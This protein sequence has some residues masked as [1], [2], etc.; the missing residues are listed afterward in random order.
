MNLLVSASFIA[1]FFAGVAALFAPCCITVLLPTY[2][3]SIF[4]QKTKVFLMTF[5]YFLG[6]LVVFIPLGLGVTALSTLFSSYHNIIYSIGAIFL[7]FLGLSLLLGRQFSIPFSVHPQLKRY[8]FPSVFILG[9]FSAFATVCCAPV[10][11][12]VLALSI[13]PGS[14]FLGVAYV[15]AYVLGMVL[16]LF[17]IAAFLDKINFTQKF[18]VFRKVVSYKLLGQKIF[19]PFSNLFA[20]LMFFILGIIILFL[21]QENSLTTHAAY[22]A[23]LN[24]FTAKLVDSISVFTR[25]IP[26]PVW[27]LVFVGIFL[28]IVRIAIKEFVDVIKNKGGEN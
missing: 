12:G 27:A 15:L 23:T 7:I 28:L 6:L 14:V 16:P 9:I 2:L 18:F 8:D 26:Q 22:Q 4:K 13:L 1:A 10:L 25:I 24:V 11:A 3:A 5:V 21:S 17:L 20:G 19:L